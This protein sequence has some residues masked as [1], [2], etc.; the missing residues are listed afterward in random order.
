MGTKCHCLICPS[1]YQ[2]FNRCK[3]YSFISTNASVW[4]D[5]FTVLENHWQKMLATVWLRDYMWRFE[6]FGNICTILKREK[7][8]W[9][10]DK[11]KLY[12]KYHPFMSIFNFLNCT[13][14]IKSHKASNVLNKLHKFHQAHAFIT[15]FNGTKHVSE[16]FNLIFHASKRMLWQSR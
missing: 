8:P 14:G 9:R 11:A 13:N 12:Y 16:S 1:M 2:I 5:S 7:H 15:R 3:N 6:Q 10:S 4:H